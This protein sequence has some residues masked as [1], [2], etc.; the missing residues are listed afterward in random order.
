MFI[1]IFRW[2]KFNTCDVILDADWLQIYFF[3]VSKERTE[4][5]LQEEPE[6]KVYYFTIYHL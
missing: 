1:F 5:G 4:G 3:V 6:G 2:M